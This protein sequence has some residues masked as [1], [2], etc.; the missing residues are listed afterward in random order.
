[1]SGL[2]K[3]K[4]TGTGYD[5]LSKNTNGTDRFIE[6]KTTK[7]TKETPIYL[8]RTEAGFALLKAKDFFLYRVYNFDSAPRIFIKNGP[9]EGFCRLRP[10]SFRGYF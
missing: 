8:T 1:L 2:P 4:V 7:L 9:Y 5:I 3:N 10:E 6:V